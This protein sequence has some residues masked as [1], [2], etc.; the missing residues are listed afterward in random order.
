MA[1][2]AVEVGVE[3]PAAGEQEAVAEAVEAGPVAAKEQE[4]A[5]GTE[6]AAGTGK[7]GEAAGRGFVGNCG[8]NNDD[9]AAEEEEVVEVVVVGVD[10]AAAAAAGN[11]G[12]VGIA[13]VAAVVVGIVVAAFA[14]ASG[15][16]RNAVATFAAEDSVGL[17]VT[18]YA[19]HRIVASAAAEG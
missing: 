9:A 7:P 18:A 5:A 14:G 8:V 13:A 17:G 4:F 2:E 16:E 15:V 11:A 1:A 10:N 12:I 19:D 3:P 6:S